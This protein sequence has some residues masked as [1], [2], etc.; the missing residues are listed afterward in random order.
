MGVD[1]ETGP[2]DLFGNGVP[3]HATI[4]GDEFGF[5]ILKWLKLRHSTERGSAA[6][7]SVPLPS[8]SPG[9]AHWSSV[10]TIEHHPSHPLEAGYLS[11]NAGLNTSP[12]LLN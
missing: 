12:A 1:S 2:T 7:S 9:C 10:L 4:R 11:S 6:A 3:S 5:A 8:D